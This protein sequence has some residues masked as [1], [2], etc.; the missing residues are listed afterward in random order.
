MDSGVYSIE[1]EGEKHRYDQGMDN[2][3]FDHP[4]NV[5]RS[6]TISSNIDRIKKRDEQLKEARAIIERKSQDGKITCDQLGNLFKDERFSFTLFGLFVEEDDL[7]LEQTYWTNKLLDWA[8]EAGDDEVSKRRERLELVNLVEAITYV[9]CREEAVSY[10]KF[11]RIFAENKMVWTKFMNALCEEHEDALEVA[12]LMNF[13]MGA[14]INPGSRLC[15]DAELR[16]KKLFFDQLGVNEKEIGLAE[17][18]KIVPFKKDFFVE[19]MFRIFDKDHTGTISQDEFIETVQQ[20]TK[21]DDDAKISFLFKL[22][23]ANGDG[24]LLEEELHDVLKAMMT[25]NGMEFEEE[26]LKHLAN[27][28]FKDGCKECRD[29]LSLDDFKE[30]LQRREGLVKNLGIMINKWLVPPRPEKKKTLKEKLLEKLPTQMM[31]ME[32]WSN[33][34]RIWI[35]F[36]VVMNI[37]IMIQ[38]VH[39]YRHFVT[40]ENGPNYFFFTS[41]ATGKA[42]L[43]NAM[44]VLVVVLRNTITYL[45]RINLSGILPLDNNIYLHKVYFYPVFCYPF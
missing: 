20:F 10:E 26:E 15:K 33:T 5:R 19:R 29:Y 30:Q 11:H 13:I 3:A 6:S 28:L 14:T 39:Y 16:L 8:G 38:R 42:I 44:M 25:E 17:F 9:E 12:E 31:T 21:D 7:D 1:G 24:Q 40:L 35:L 43:F 2:A 34:L 36:I 18:K 37:A 23:D 32:Y 45:R 41:R 4:E 27:M 22:Y